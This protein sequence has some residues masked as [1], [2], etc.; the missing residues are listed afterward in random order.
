[1]AIDLASNN[2]NNNAITFLFE[3]VSAVVDGISSFYLNSPRTLFAFVL[4]LIYLVYYLRI[5]VQVSFVPSD[6]LNIDLT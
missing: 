5:V 2:S 3:T 4:I 1:M 6:C